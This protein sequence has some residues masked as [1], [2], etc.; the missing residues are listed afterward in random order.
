MGDDFHSWR[1]VAVPVNDCRNA[2]TTALMPE[3]IS[4][5]DIPVCVLEDVPQQMRL[6]LSARL[7][8]LSLWRLNLMW[9]GV[10]TILFRS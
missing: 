8:W 10:L 9:I 2:I 3:R 7:T 5:D 6:T 1:I 4:S